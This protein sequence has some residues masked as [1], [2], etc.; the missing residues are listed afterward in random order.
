MKKLVILLLAL[1]S[2]ISPVAEPPIVESMPEIPMIVEPPVIETPVEVPA[3]PFCTD[4]DGLNSFEKGVTETLDDRVS[5]SCLHLK[6]NGKIPLNRVVEYFCEENKI[7]AEAIDCKNGCE[8]GACLRE[9]KPLPPVHKLISSGACEEGRLIDNAI[10]I[11]KCYNDCLS[12]TKCV[13]TPHKGRQ[14]SL[15]WQL[16]C[17]VRTNQWVV[18][19]WVEFDVLT[20]I[21]AAFSANVSGSEVLSVEIRDLADRVVAVPINQKLVGENRCFSFTI[22]IAQANLN[23]GSYVVRIGAR[24]VQPHLLRSFRGHDFS[25]AFNR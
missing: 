20:P 10:R 24:A 9:A 2:C 11:T 16:N 17:L 6:N 1:V 22:G 7:V 13:R 23:P 5:D 18:N 19:K 12:D 8:N 21:Q 3:Q 14:I 4:S 15:P 25:V